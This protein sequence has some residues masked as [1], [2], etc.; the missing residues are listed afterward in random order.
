M[1]TRFLTAV[2]LLS[3]LFDGQ[4]ANRVRA[5]EPAAAP[6]DAKIE[7]ANESPG[8]AEAPAGNEYA[9]PATA[10][11]PP[12]AAA[13]SDYAQPAAAPAKPAAKKPIQ[14]WKINLFE[15]DFSYKKDPEHEWL[16]GEN[17]K[18][19]PLD[20]YGP[21]DSLDVPILFSTGGEV[22]L[23]QM[24]EFNR[25]RPGAPA[26]GDYQLWRW[27]HY[28]DLKVDDWFRVYAEMIDASM[29]NN[30]LPVLGIDVN[31]WDL[32]NLFLDLKFLQVGER[33]LWMRVGRQE[34]LYGSQRLVSPLDWA[35]TRRNFEGLKFF[36]KGADWDFDL[37]FTRTLN[38]ATPGDG[39][40]SL[41]ANHFDSPNMNHT[42]SGAWFAYKAVKNQT[43]DLY[44]LWD[45]NTQFMAQNFTGGNRHTLATRWL[46]DFPVLE[47][48]TAVRTWH[49]EVEGGGQFG[50]DF[51]RNVV[52]GFVVAGGGLT[53]NSLPWQPDLWFY[54]DYASGSNNLQS[55]T[56]NTFAQ[57]YGLVHAYLGQI[58]NVARQNISDIN[59]KFTVKPLKQ[60]TVQSQY[61]WFDLANPSDVLYNI[62]GQ[63]VGKP[64]TGRHVGEEIDLVATYNF[65]PNLSMQLG[66]LW[67]WNGPFVATNLPRGTG[68]LLYLQTTFSY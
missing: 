7:S 3:C 56:S 22:R 50:N 16:L 45:W 18:D 51:G 40:V 20:D 43:V 59:G 55:R 52:A 23:R 33:D 6:D 63:P 21:F 54:Y 30:P 62:A 64:N 27:R 9:T 44:W 66:Y 1:L 49:G 68:E 12:A 41:F 38:T 36:T 65:S 60:L 2:L 10:A 4:F 17:L 53:W 57:Q 25:L 67:F 26:R 19:I 8:S 13:S 35:N 48:E 28:V 29:D 24:D 15:N 58:D 5:R 11:A 34:L 14:P 61:H 47:G 42:F 37:W 32:Q 31:R 46:R 39:P